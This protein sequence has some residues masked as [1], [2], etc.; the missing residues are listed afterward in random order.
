[1][2]TESHYLDLRRQVLEQRRACTDEYMRVKLETLGLALLHM[3]YIP[4]DRAYMAALKDAVAQIQ[5]EPSLDPPPLWQS[6][7][8]KLLACREA[9]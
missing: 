6:E 7:L 9:E 3:S 8:T 5:K 2:T 1:M 4:S